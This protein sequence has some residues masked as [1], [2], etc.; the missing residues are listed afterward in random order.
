MPFAASL[1]GQASSGQENTNAHLEEKEGERER[2]RERAR[3]E[4]KGTL[5]LS[6]LP[7]AT[8]ERACAGVHLRFPFSPSLL[9][10]FLTKSNRV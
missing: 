7:A 2:E 1:K 5:M 10:L 9:P 6:I 4:K 3:K 8:N